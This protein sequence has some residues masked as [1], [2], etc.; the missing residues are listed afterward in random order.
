MR[1]IYFISIFIF[2]ACY[3]QQMSWQAMMRWV[4]TSFPTVQQMSTQDLSRILESD[5]VKP[6][7]LDARKSQE[8]E[9]SHLKNAQLIDPDATNFPMLNRVDKNTLI[10]VY[11]SVGYRSS[12]IAKRLQEAGFTQVRNLEGSIFKWANEGRPIY[13]G[14]QQVHQ[15][16]PYDRTWG[17]LLNRRLRSEIHP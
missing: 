6:L 16:H 9:V 12:A 14:N 11:C 1:A 3:A 4:R 10:V 5:G 7:L 8:F 13:R 2:Q 15:V 17:R